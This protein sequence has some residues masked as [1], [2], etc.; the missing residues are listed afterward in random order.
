MRGRQAMRGPV[1][2]VGPP[3]PHAPHQSANGQYGLVAMVGPLLLTRQLLL[4]APQAPLLAPAH[5]NEGEALP[6]AGRHREH[7][8]PVY[9]NG[10]QAV[11]RRRGLARLHTEGDEP[12]V[13]LALDRRVAQRAT[14]V[15]GPAKP[16]PPDLAKLDLGP[17]S[18][19]P[20]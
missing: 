5:A 13:T 6:V 8:T 9:P 15:A 18:V 16:N 19:Q 12:I 7:N 20:P 4:Q 11:G 3:V 14:E 10:W 1:G 2:E 17:P